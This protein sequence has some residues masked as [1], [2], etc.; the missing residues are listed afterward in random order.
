MKKVVNL[1]LITAPLFAVDLIFFGVGL[2]VIF[3]ILLPLAFYLKAKSYR[4]ARGLMQI[5]PSTARNITGDRSLRGSNSWQ[6]Y[7]LDLNIS[8]GQDLI[9][10]LIKS[11]KIKYSLV[12][13]LTAWNAGPSRLDK[14]DRKISVYSDPLLYIESI[15]STETRLFV[16]KV[17]SDL[18]VY[19]DR[20]EQ[21]KASLKQLANNK[22]PEY[23]KMEN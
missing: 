16:K 17:L 12:K 4:G 8:T 6:L 18:W 21:N 22:W 5:L 13:L 7:D 20:F 3:I 9:L 11:E 14:W 1:L 10:K 15:P 23:L 2:S 19:R